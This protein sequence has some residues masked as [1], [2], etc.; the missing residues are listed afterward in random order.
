MSG[1]PGVPRPAASPSWSGSPGV[2]TSAHTGEDESTS[3]AAPDASATMAV[4]AAGAATERNVSMRVMVKALE[5]NAETAMES[6]GKADWIG[7]ALL[8]KPDEKR[9]TDR[10]TN[11]F[12]DL[13]VM[14]G[15]G[16]EDI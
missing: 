10:R 7:E 16:W 2:G 8:G 15:R 13:F 11:R 9:E 5:T 6:P 3:P 1:V 14:Q 12:S 4:Q